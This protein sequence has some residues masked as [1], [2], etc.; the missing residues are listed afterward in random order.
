MK[1]LMNSVYSAWPSSQQV[2][3]MWG[4]LPPVVALRGGWWKGDFRQVFSKEEKFNNCMRKDIVVRYR[5]YLAEGTTE[6]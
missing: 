5:L 1:L 6:I 4:G 3:K 2:M